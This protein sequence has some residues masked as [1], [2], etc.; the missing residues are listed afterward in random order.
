MVLWKNSDDNIVDIVGGEII[1]IELG[2]IDSGIDMVEI[3][4]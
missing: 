3:I 2:T 4:M 1:M